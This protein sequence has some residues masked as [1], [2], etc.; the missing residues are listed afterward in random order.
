MPLRDYQADAI[1]SAYDF[2]RTRTG[3]NPCIVIPTGG[4]KTPILSTICHDAVTKWRGRVLVVSHVKELVEQSANTL[5]LWYDDLDVGVYSAGVGSRDKR[6]DVIVAGIQS[7][8]NKGLDL[9]GTKPFNLVLVDEAHRIPTDGDGQYQQLLKDLQAANPAVRVI[10]LTATPYRMKGGYVCSPDH[11]LNDIC[12][13]VSV[14]ELI[15]RG[16]L[17][18][19]TSKGSHNDA[20]LSSVSVR[21]GEYVASDMERAFEEII[22]SAVD[23]IVHYAKERKSVLIFCAGVDHAQKVTD[24]LRELAG[25]EGV[26][27]IY[28]S[29]NKFDRE[30]SV[31]SFKIGSTKYLCNVN[32]LTEGFDA[33][34]VDMVVLLRA[35]LSPGLYYQMVGRGL[36][37]HEGKQD[38]MVLDFGSNVATHGPIDAIRVRGGKSTGTGEAPTKTC[39]ECKEIVPA[40]YSNCSECGYE[41]PPPE[42]KPR[43]EPKASSEAILSEHKPTTYYLVTDVYYAVH[44]KKDWIEGQPRTLRVDYF[45]GPARVASEWVCL[46]HD[47]YAKNKAVSWWGARCNAKL[48]DTIEDAVSIASLDLILKPIQIGVRDAAGGR[49]KEIVDVTF[50]DG[51]QPEEVDQEWLDD[52]LRRANEDSEVPF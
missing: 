9:A 24:K 3:E 52:Y 27:C 43:H 30:R 23:E 48:P 26:D 38:C 11:F 41:F 16:Y 47:G 39:P 32:V 37:L 21:G 42:P 1:Q 20:D 19:L 49:F 51:L 2:L 36:R 40:N 7:I 33:T 4:G 15:A 12:Y 34:R 31:N 50:G 5:R 10:G 46:E 17:S 14:R 25:S 28:G 18:R 44:Y 6:N 45:D 8:Y 35:T 22:D 29:T 13:E